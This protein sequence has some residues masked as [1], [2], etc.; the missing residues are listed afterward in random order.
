MIEPSRSLNELIRL[1][2]AQ[3]QSEKI[4]AIIRR[5]EM[6]QSLKL[7]CTLSAAAAAVPETR[8]ALTVP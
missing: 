1:S 8:A 4:D 7:T 2:S 3:L 5:R 6:L